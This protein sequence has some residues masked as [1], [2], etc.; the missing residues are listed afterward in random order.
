MACVSEV[1]P[2]VVRGVVELGKGKVVQVEI[3]AHWPE[4]HS[5]EPIRDLHRLS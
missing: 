2:V 4:A 5:R 1:V 3:P